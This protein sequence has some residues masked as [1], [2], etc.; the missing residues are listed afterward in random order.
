MAIVNVI[1]VDNEQQ[2]RKQCNVKRYKRQSSIK[3]KKKDNKYSTLS[4]K[5]IIVSPLAI[6]FVDHV[7]DYVALNSESESRHVW[8]WNQRNVNENIK[9]NIFR[10]NKGAVITNYC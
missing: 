5:R 6:F 8:N 3:K 10:S 1:L 4:A 2:I 7:A 9:E